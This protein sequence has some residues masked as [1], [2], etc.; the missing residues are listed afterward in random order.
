[1]NNN[2]DT[3]DILESSKSPFDFKK[4]FF[5]A[6]QYWYFIPI[7]LTLAIVL[8]VYMYKTTL[9]IYKISAEIMITGTDRG[10]ASVGSDEGAFTG[11]TLGQQN[12]VSNQLIIL[13]S[14]EQIKKTLKQLDFSVSYYQQGM[15]LIN[16]IYKESPFK[17]IPDTS[18][19]PLPHNT[20]CIEFINQ[21]E[22]YLTIDGNKEYKKKFKLFEKISEPHFEFTVAPV[23]KIAKSKK[24]INNTYCFKF[25]SMDQ[26]IQ[27]Y[28]NKI[29]IEQIGRSSIYEI[30][31]T[32]NNIQKGIDFLNKLAQNSVDYTLEKKNQIANNTIQF[33][34]NQ[35]ISV[36]DS[37]SNAKK[38]LENF[39]S[40][41][42]VMDVSMQGQMII[43]QSQ[44]LEN[45]RH[46]V[47]Q[48]LD[49]YNYLLDYVQNNRDKEEDLTPPSS[50]N[51]TDP[52]LSRL[53]SE[54]ST[55]NAEKASLLF[56]SSSENPNVT[57]LN[58][59]IKTI[60]N[61]IVENT[62]NLI[63]TTER[64]LA[65]I[66]N[67]LM[68]LSYEIRKLPRTEQML[69]DI[70]RKFEMN[71]ELHTHLLERRANAQLAKAA[72]MPDNEII[73]YAAYAGKVKPDKT[74]SILVV[75][76]LGLF[77]P[78]VIIFL[79]IFLNDK[80]QDKDDL[81]GI[82]E[83]VLGSVPQQKS[84]RKNKKE[85]EIVSNPRSAIAEAFRSIRTSLE[86]YP[87]NGKC[88]T[89]LLTSSLPGEGKSFTATNLAISYAQLKKKTILIEFDLR[90]PSLRKLLN[91]KK[92]KNKGLLSRFLI[93]NDDNYKSG[94]IENTGIE[95][96]DII[97][98]GDIPPNPVELIAGEKTK[99]LF[100]QLK[101]LYDVIIID[102]PPLGLVTDAIILSG[103]ADINLLIVRH[104]VT[105]LKTLMEILKDDNI[106]NMKNLGVII[107]S[108]PL[109]KRGY[110]YKYGYGVK[111]DY[112][113]NS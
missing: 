47:A 98:A 101:N 20:F 25:N 78:S 113:T 40:Q 46:R 106:K 21:N 55:L 109:K 14:T 68:K 22:F 11:V 72:N 15:F 67:R 29:Q 76:M 84:K 88:K 7:F 75:L 59:R 26:L 56:N 92:G 61:S 9:P 81:E 52:L 87:A 111:S 103:Y 48:Q 16:E 70:Q 93:S 27:K 58:R 17:V 95:N 80:V 37:L 31:I 19:V 41:N 32:E 79:I 96:L 50:Q 5:R 23:E 86:F 4:A 100:E 43:Q 36:T 90:K 102:T 44:Q 74:R 94:L 33:I 8:A 60:K 34:D 112:Y 57:R 97:F 64:R 28:K 13:R 30:S 108:L 42:K 63:K 51:V 66:D 82:K 69:A 107:N 10:R 89:I 2:F 77:F 85:L 73:E 83:P 71:D 53:I 99:L 3:T 39:R 49:Y 62:K 18:K 38:I 91:I 65:D 24:Y 35:L 1:M 12:N 105:P 110:S 6:L 54:L 104:N 45:E